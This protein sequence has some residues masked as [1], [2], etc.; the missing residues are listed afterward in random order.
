MVRRTAR[1]AIGEGG[2]GTMPKTQKARHRAGP[3][4][5]GCRGK[6]YIQVKSAATSCVAAVR[7]STVIV[8]SAT[9][10]PLVSI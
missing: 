7:P 4:A 3:L 6:N 2:P 9:P 1:P 5:S 8:M 10:L